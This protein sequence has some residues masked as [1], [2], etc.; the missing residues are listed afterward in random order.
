MI[1]LVAL[2]G[3]GTLRE[4]KMC[5]TS[6]TDMRGQGFNNPPPPFQQGMSPNDAPPMHLAQSNTPPP[7]PPNAG[8]QP[9][10]QH[11]ASNLQVGYAPGAPG[12]QGVPPGYQ[13]GNQG[14]K[15]ST[16]GNM[17][18]GPGHA[19]QKNPGHQGGSGY[20]SSSQHPPLF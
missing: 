17:H 19:Y 13:G 20:T 2:I 9:T 18:G 12:Y 16:G 3:Q 7:P 11:H 15:A 4:G 6:K 5:R 8:A 14:Y 1:G 10:Y